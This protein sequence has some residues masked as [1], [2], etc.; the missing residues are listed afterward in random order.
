MRSTPRDTGRMASVHSLVFITTAMASANGTF[1]DGTPWSMVRTATGSY[2]FYFDHR[3]VPISGSVGLFQNARIVP[4]LG[5][6]DPGKINVNF[7]LW[8]GTAV[9]AQFKLNLTWLDNRT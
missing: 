2:D 9:N 1:S 8:D 5:S 3:L 6:F 4:N 7:L